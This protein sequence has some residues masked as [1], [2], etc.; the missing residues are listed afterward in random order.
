[1][2]ISPAGRSPTCPTRAVLKVDDLRP[3]TPAISSA[4]RTA[5]PEGASF[6]IRWWASTISTS[7]PS[8][9]DLASWPAI[10]IIRFTPTDML[11][12]ITTGI[13]LAASATS[14]FVSGVKPVEPITIGTFFS[15]QIRACARLA[16]AAVKS[17]T[18][19][20]RPSAIARSRSSRTG[21]PTS[22]KRAA[23]PTSTPRN[24]EPF[25][26]V[27][28]TTR[29]SASLPTIRTRVAPIRP[30]TPVTIVRIILNK[31]QSLELVLQFY[32]RRLGGWHQRQPNFRPEPIHQMQ[33]PFH[34]DRAGFDEKQ[35][36]QSIHLD[37]DLAGA[38]PLAGARELDQ[39]GHHPGRHV[40]GNGDHPHPPAGDERQDGGIVTGDERQTLSTLFKNVDRPRHAGGGLFD[41][42]H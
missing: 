17:I 1:M 24:S 32:R 16:E 9:S 13:F 39:V 41:R 27:P 5:V 31:S 11:G 29:M 19:S 40:A 36:V 30:F 42:H 34:R 6:F 14:A 33:R 12:A 18:T 35:L 22:L 8:P 20:G 28:P 15:A 25:L 4:S 2:P 26:S 10:L 38:R 21:T 3:S 37:L 23:A 7:K